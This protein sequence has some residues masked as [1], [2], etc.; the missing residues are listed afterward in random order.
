MTRA[1][2]RKDK[3]YYDGLRADFGEASP[4]ASGYLSE[5][6]FSPKNALWCWTPWA[7]SR[8]RYWTWHAAAGWSACPWPRLASA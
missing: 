3:I 7:M 8:A 4:K 5:Y 1:D 2:N 6:S